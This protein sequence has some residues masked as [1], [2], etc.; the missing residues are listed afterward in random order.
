MDELNEL[1]S[2]L[3]ARQQKFVD[4]HLNGSTAKQAYKDAYDV[5]N[6]GTAE[7][8]GCKLLRNAKISNYI[9]AI[10]EQTQ[11]ETIATRTEILEG[12]TKVFRL[13]VVAVESGAETAETCKSTI[14]ASIA[15]GQQISKMQGYDAPTEVINHNVD[16]S[17][18]KL[19]EEMI[20]KGFGRRP[21]QL[22]GKK[23]DE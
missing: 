3:N 18:E 14:R 8:N 16:I 23:A 2:K 22:A 6:D 4:Y 20:K 15:A 7:V 10:Q 19:E 17:D 12:L 13:G 5:D 21:N 11:K 1:R 9:K